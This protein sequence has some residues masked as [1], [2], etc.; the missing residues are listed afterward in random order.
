MI[1]EM[2]SQYEHSQGNSI[3]AVNTFLGQSSEMIFTQPTQLTSERFL[4]SIRKPKL[5]LEDCDGIEKKLKQCEKNIAKSLSENEIESEGTLFPLISC[6]LL[7]LFILYISRVNIIADLSDVV[8][9]IF[10]YKKWNSDPDKFLNDV[11]SIDDIDNYVSKNLLFHSF[12]NNYLMDFN[13]VCGIRMSLKLANLIENSYKDY[14]VTDYIKQEFTYLAKS[15]NPGEETNRQGIWEYNFK[16]FRGVGGYT[17][18]FMQTSYEEALYQWREMKPIFLNKEVFES[19]VIEVV[20]HNSNLY[21][22]LYYFQIFNRESSGRVTIET[23]TS[24][25]SPEM[26]ASQNSHFF[27]ITIILCFYVFILA[28]QLFKFFIK[29]K[30]ILKESFT[31]MNLSMTSYDF[32]ELVLVCMVLILLSLFIKLDLGNI[33]NFYLPLDRDSFDKIID[34]AVEFRV[35]LRVESLTCLLSILKLVA[36]LQVQF[37]S[38]GVLFQTL[39]ISKNDLINLCFIGIILILSLVLATHLVSGIHN[40][41]NRTFIQTCLQLFDSMVGVMGFNNSSETNKSVKFF[42]N[43]IFV[44]LFSFVFVRYLAA[45]V[46]STYMFLKN[47]D[48]LLLAAKAEIIK[49]KTRELFKIIIN[50]ILFRQKT[51]I[52]NDTEEYMKIKCKANEDD[53]LI[54]PEIQE[55]LKSLENS[56]KRQS[57]IDLWV[58][59]KFNLATLSS[60]L[61]EKNLEPQTAVVNRLKEQIREILEKEKKNDIIMQKKELDVEYNFSMFI[62]MIVFILWL[63]L[64][65]Y[66]IKL[67]LNIH[68]SYHMKLVSKNSISLKNFTY[69]TEMNVD[70]ITSYPEVEAFIDQIFFELL[71]E[72]S[73]YQNYLYLN[74]SIRITIQRYNFINNTADFSKNTIPV[75]LSSG[76]NLTEFR[77]KSSKLLYS[78]YDINED[79]SYG[80]KGGISL[81][82]NS[83][84][85]AKKMFLL[86]KND[87]VSSRNCSSIVLEWV[88]YNRNLEY[89][90]Y[91][92]LVFTQGLSGKIS[93]EFKSIS[94]TPQMYIGGDI[95]I[96][97]LSFLS[98][99]ICIYLS[100]RIFKEFIRVWKKLNKKR[101]SKAKKRERV[102][103]VIEEISKGQGKKDKNTQDYLNVCIRSIIYLIAMNITQMIRATYIFFTKDLE[104]AIEITSYV[105]AYGTLF[106]SLKFCISPMKIESFDDFYDSAEI[107]EAYKIMAAYNF[108]FLFIRIPKYFLLS[109]KMAFLISIMGKARLDFLFF[110]MMYFTIM[111]GFMLMGHIMLGHYH[112]GY[113][114][115]ENSFISGY[116]LRFGYFDYDLYYKADHT[117]G[118]IY[119]VLF[120]VTIIFFLSSMFVSIITGYYKDLLPSYSSKIGLLSK[121]LLTFQAKLKGE[122]VLLA[123]EHEEIDIKPL[124]S[125]ES[126][127][128]SQ[129]DDNKY[130]ILSDNTDLYIEEKI[131]K[132]SMTNGWIHQ[133]E[134]E[135]MCRTRG[136]LSLSDLYSKSPQIQSP[137]FD[138]KELV[139]MNSHVWNLEPLESKVHI[140]NSLA[141]INKQELINNGDMQ[142]TLEVSGVT[143]KGYYCM[144]NI[145]ENFRP[146]V[147]PRLKELWES[148]SI[149]DKISM[150]ISDLNDEGRHIIWT[151]VPYPE[152]IN[153][154]WGNLSISEKI[155]RC[156]SFLNISQDYILPYLSSKN[157]ISYLCS[158][159]IPEKNLLWLSLT[160]KQKTKQNLCIR[161]LTLEETEILC[162]SIIL[163]LSN[164]ILAIEKVDLLMENIFDNEIY[165][166]LENASWGQAEYGRRTSIRQS[167]EDSSN[168]CSNLLEYKTHLSQDR[169]R[170]E[171]TNKKLISQVADLEGNSL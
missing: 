28:V 84:D 135:L 54:N 55:K 21:S 40:F 59:L 19:L 24:G 29:F 168:D 111:F 22:T 58:R 34:Y 158:L 47:R 141:K 57:N 133:V 30:R 71:R 16:S 4:E 104:R 134:H 128:I 68:D 8:I 36:Q 25:I 63:L 35:L 51:S 147:S 143:C 121:L 10:E 148:L 122:S 78:S 164:N 170:Y 88:F 112:P 145:I 146:E 1:I 6:A 161:C 96:I 107:L 138:I 27:Q 130:I 45:I 132:K 129:I 90:T 11:R 42:Y 67:E 83:Y 3:D 120:I 23:G 46:M 80:R 124:Y 101:I 166:K 77:G 115:L 102:L 15:Y 126:S 154:N 81:T 108:F 89:L 74:K 65:L 32:L 171:H 114:T 157:P 5:S 116:F 169:A 18:Y 39:K 125:K 73:S 17:A 87:Q 149:H 167:I 26:Y 56:I 43:I 165:R 156:K 131:S 48:Q 144:N 99:I 44:I 62:E 2:K 85:N 31:K 106:T 49:K 14:N 41:S 82:L 127:D 33:G 94:I 20:I 151:I 137:E 38:F 117:L 37:P 98:L 113:A 60:F 109:S 66:T 118:L 160:G 105:F 72:E 75:I 12:R 123:Q 136:K 50:L 13:Y 86:I 163:E 153:I 150:W 110:L 162:C 155:S 69:L 119:I 95:K 100:L 76:Y 93:H 9:S 103:A 97:T 53:T 92:I 152:D 61:Q 79:G 159:K 91:N 142:K 7:I 140:W 139:Y 52:Y 64:I 70:Q